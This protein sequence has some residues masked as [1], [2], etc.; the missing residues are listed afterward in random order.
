MDMDVVWQ[1]IETSLM[2]FQD[3]H[4]ALMD[5]TRGLRI[6]PESILFQSFSD[7]QNIAVEFISLLV[8]DPFEFISW[9]CCECEYG[10]RPMKAGPQK[11]Q[12]EIASIEDLRWL[13]EST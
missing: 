5:G 7:A 4:H 2:K 1:K 9:Y 3:D 12:R 8:D 13:I 10:E 6:E 11:D